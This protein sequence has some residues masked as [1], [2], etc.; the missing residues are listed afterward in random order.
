MKKL[1]LALAL[2][3]WFTTAPT[4]AADKK[5]VLIAGKPS[6]GPGEHE[7]NA[8][9][10]LFQ[11]CLAAV[12]GINVVEISG[13]WPT[14]EAMLND[15]AAIVIYG[16]GGGGH[17][18]LQGDH[19]KTL[20]ALMEKGVGL[21]CIHYAVEPT[22]DRGEKEFLSWLG[23]CFEINWSVNP[24]WQAEF[25]SL[26]A[27]PITR[28]VQPFA[29]Q[30]EWYFNM[31][32]VDGMKGVTP[33]LT[34]VP[35]AATMS[36][37]DGPHEG[38]PAVRSAV[39]AGEPQTV[40]WAFENAYGGRGFGFTGGHYHKNWADANMRKLVLNGILWTAKVEVPKDGVA[41][42]VTADDLKAHLDAK[43]PGAKR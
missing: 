34:A 2:L 40:A 3:A 12:P 27:H 19:L 41:S 43:T 37:S 33:I 28:G 8:G 25:K 4:F 16:D 1:F 32:F 23:G 30:D 7:H 5:I 21:V 15:A 20:D 18:A 17:P 9:L 29:L 31:R 42:E 39:A 24:V 6:H 35:P 26:P 36:R 13:G 10:L 38:N 11:K 14:N 22:L